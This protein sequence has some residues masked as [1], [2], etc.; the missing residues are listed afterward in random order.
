VRNIGVGHQGLVKF[1]GAMNMLAP[2]NANSYTNHVTAIHGAADVVA[3][4][5]MKS[6]AEETKQF[7]EPEEDGV[8]DIGI[9]VDGTWRQRGYSFSYGVVTG[10][11][12]I[13]GKVLDVEVMSKECWECITW[14]SKKGSEEFEHWWEGHQHNCSNRGVR[15]RSVARK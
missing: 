10:M 11:S 7:Y 13:T 8:H 5:S 4:A 6:A 2:M 14:S 1:C 3:K 9:T 15:Q 12:L